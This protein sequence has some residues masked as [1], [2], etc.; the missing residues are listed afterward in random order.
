MYPKKQRGVFVNSPQGGKKIG[1]LINGVLHMNRTY[2]LHHYNKM[3]GWAIDKATLD[4]NLHRIEAFMIHSSGRPTPTGAIDELLSFTPDDLR[5]FLLSIDIIN[6][7]HGSQYL[8]PD[9]VWE[10]VTSSVIPTPEVVA[11][12]PHSSPVT[13][14]YDTHSALPA[15]EQDLPMVPEEPPLEDWHEIPMNVEYDLNTTIFYKD[16]TD[17]TKFVYPTNRLFNAIAVRPLLEAGYVI[18]Y[19][20][21]GEGFYFVL[22]N[23]VLLLRKEGTEFSTPYEFSHKEEQE[24]S[25]SILR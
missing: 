5:S 9:A 13:K 22:E 14:T 23:N 19:P 7:G 1:E 21:L 15:E 12:F 16:K 2:T 4:A 17:D 20:S 10:P 18:G 8:F 6:F 25:F 11:Y 3:P 24:R